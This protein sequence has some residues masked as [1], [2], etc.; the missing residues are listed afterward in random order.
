[1]IFAS[2]KWTIGF[3]PHTMIVIGCTLVGILLILLFVTL[4][5]DLFH[6]I[7]RFDNRTF[8]ITVLALTACISTYA[9]NCAYKPTIKKVTIALPKLERSVKIVQLSDLHVGH[10][11]GKKSLRKIVKQV[12]DSEPDIVV[13]TGDCF[14]SWYNFNHKSVAPLENLDAHP[15]FVSG[16]HEGYVNDSSAKKLLSDVGVQILENQIITIDNLC[17]VGLSFMQE[18]QI[19]TTLNAIT[20]DKAFPVIVLQHSPIGIEAIEKA[21]VDLLLAG[22][23]HGGQL[24]PFTILN[25][26]LFKYNR[27]L[28]K[29][30]SLQLYTS[31]GIGTFGPPMRIGTQSEITLIELVPQ[32]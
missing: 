9:I 28:F 23:T 11:R 16:N 20:L 21:G 18:E 25:H 24:F 2:Q 5:V 26:Y 7:F 6:L 8:F 1:M 22:H 10:F 19:E 17:I 14:D 4:A 29:K 30:D 32:N 13:I 31:V 3:F 12:N 15:Y 27:G